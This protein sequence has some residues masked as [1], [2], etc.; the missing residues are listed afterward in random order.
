MSKVRTVKMHV[1][2]AVKPR[3][4]LTV[5]RWIWAPNLNIQSLKLNSA[6][7]GTQSVP[8]N[9]LSEL[10]QHV[11]RLLVEESHFVQIRRYDNLELVKFLSLAIIDFPDWS[12]L[13]KTIFNFCINNIQLDVTIIRSELI[14]NHNLSFSIPYD[15]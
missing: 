9:K 15:I 4:C 2:S 1:A 13:I 12:G 10:D 14:L 5:A 6:T 11:G 7:L 3:N 8:G